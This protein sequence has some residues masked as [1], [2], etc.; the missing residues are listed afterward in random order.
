MPSEQYI[1]ISSSK[2]HSFIQYMI[3]ELPW[4]IDPRLVGRAEIKH[5][6]VSENPFNLKKEK[7]KK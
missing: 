7:K 3:A 4:M 2:S 5:I 1:E 6:N